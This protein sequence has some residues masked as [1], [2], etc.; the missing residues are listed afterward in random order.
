MYVHRALPQAS[1]S[2]ADLI[3]N[4]LKYFIFLYA[5]AWTHIHGYSQGLEEGIESPGAR[6]A[7]YVMSPDVGSGN[8]NLV[9]CKRR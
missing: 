7:G 3:K 5:C 4:I 1:V 2:L 6:V 9:L 8:S